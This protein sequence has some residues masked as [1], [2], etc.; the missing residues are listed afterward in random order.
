MHPA[1]LAHAQHFVQFLHRVRV[2]MFAAARSRPEVVVAADENACHQWAKRRRVV[3]Q[4]SRSSETSPPKHR[5]PAEVHVA[6]DRTHSRFSGK[7][8]WMSEHAKTR[9]GG[10][11]RVGRLDGT[12]RGRRH[13]RGGGGDGGAGIGAAGTRE[14]WRDDGGGSTRRRVRARVRRGGCA[15]VDDA[16]SRGRGEGRRG[17]AHVRS[18]RATSPRLRFDETRVGS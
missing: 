7:S 18:A 16:T 14:D 1:C 5:V 12:A 6:E 11:V 4:N 3:F 13:A 8:V 15:R 9:A 10:D 17:R 2:A